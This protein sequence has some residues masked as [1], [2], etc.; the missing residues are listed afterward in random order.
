MTNKQRLVAVRMLALPAIETDDPSS[1]ETEAYLDEDKN[2]VVD[3]W[4]S[5]EITSGHAPKEVDELIIKK[6]ERVI[7]DMKNLLEEIR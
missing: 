2:I 1:S 5:G 7:N 6:L 4:S 3:V